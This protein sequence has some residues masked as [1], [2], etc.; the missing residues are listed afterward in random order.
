MGRAA[1]FVGCA[2]WGFWLGSGMA[3]A[4]GSAASPVLIE[5]F[6][7]EGCSSCPPADEFLRQLD[8]QQPIQ[9]ARLIVLSEHVDYWDGQ[10]WKDPFA[11]SDFTTRQTR[12]ERALKVHEPY[13]PQFVVDGSADMRLTQREAIPRLLTSA[14]KNAKVP[15][16]IDSV[17][18]DPGSP[19]SLKG[20]ITV[21]GTAESRA[22]ELFV[23]LALDHADSNVLRG[24]NR[25]HVLTHVAVLRE[26][27]SL[28]PVEPGAIRQLDFKLPLQTS[29]DL[30]IVTFLQDSGL[31]AV[32]GVADA[33]TTVPN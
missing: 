31:G 10:G 30:R 22:S 6:T 1:R 13:T 23:A 18:I 5:L 2:C 17:Q 19:R 9:G 28:G 7:A 24:E 4:E 20:T 16:K 33:R 32:R 3:M 21:D 8:A 25:G 29:G 14:A 26:L 12:Y 11:S 15:I 27:V